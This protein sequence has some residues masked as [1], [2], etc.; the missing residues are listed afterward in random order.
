MDEHAA[1]IADL[2]KRLVAANAGT[3]GLI[4]EAPAP[5]LPQPG[6]PVDATPDGSASPPD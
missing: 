2:R 5:A 1:T 3:Q 4:V 6:P